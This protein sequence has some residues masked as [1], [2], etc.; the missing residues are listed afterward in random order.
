MLEKLNIRCY[1]YQ[2]IKQFYLLDDVGVSIV[3]VSA[4]CAV[5]VN[6]VRR[7]FFSG[8]PICNRQI[9]RGSYFCV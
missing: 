2:V 5:C 3:I 6:R 4:K 7:S 8:L 9:V 1:S